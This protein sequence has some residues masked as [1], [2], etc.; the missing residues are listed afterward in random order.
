MLCTRL[1][2]SNPLSVL[3]HG[4]SVVEDAQGRLISSVSGVRSGDDIT[5]KLQDGELSAIVS[6]TRIKKEIEG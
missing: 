2:A 6:D 3:S 5:V 1:E 4:Y